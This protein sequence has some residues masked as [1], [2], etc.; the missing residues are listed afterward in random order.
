MKRGKQRNMN[1]RLMST[2]NA[3][4]GGLTMGVKWGQG[5]GEQGGKRWDHC[6]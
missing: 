6:N 5:C 3:G 2:D 1:R 4:R